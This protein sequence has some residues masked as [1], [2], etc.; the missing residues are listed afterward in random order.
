VIATTNT[1]TV[2]AL[3]IAG[4]A[5]LVTT[6]TLLL[7]YG[8]AWWREHRPLKVRLAASVSTLLRPSPPDPETGKQVASRV[9]SLAVVDVSCVNLSDVPVRVINTGFV[10]RRS[11]VERIRRKPQV[12]QVM[13]WPNMTREL[14]ADLPPR[15]RWQTSYRWDDLKI[16]LDEKVRA[17]CLLDDGRRGYSTRIRMRKPSIDDASVREAPDAPEGPGIL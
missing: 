4:Y 14:P 1:L 13:P 6:F 11:L 12:F 8:R 15:R 9:Q 7:G 3:V 10:P 16:N 5:A 2:V 17:Y